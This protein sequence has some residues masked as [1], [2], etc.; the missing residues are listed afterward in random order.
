MGKNNVRRANASIGRGTTQDGKGLG[1]VE[2]SP[3]QGVPAPPR[4][5]EN[6]IPLPGYSGAS[7]QATKIVLTTEKIHAFSNFKC[8]HRNK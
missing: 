6:F 1:I 5:S 8:R 4:E 3:P 2:L 7:K